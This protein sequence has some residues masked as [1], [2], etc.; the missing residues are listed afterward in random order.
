MF[1]IKKLLLS[2]TRKSLY[3]LKERLEKEEKHIMGLAQINHM[4]DRITTSG[5]L[6]I[7]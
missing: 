6:V 4:N 2:P 1:P 7:R 5:K 3:I